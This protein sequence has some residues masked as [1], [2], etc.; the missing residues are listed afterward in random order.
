MKKIVKLIGTTAIIVVFLALNATSA[1]AQIQK[2]DEPPVEIK[3]PI[4]LPPPPPVI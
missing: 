2:P 1:F 3:P 4:L